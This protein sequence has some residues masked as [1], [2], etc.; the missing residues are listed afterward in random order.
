MS[1]S[2]EGGFFGFE[3]GG[4]GEEGGV[5]EVLAVFPSR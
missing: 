4:A 1:L 3:G 2:E 5:W